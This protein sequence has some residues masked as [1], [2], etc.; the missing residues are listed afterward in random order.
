MTVRRLSGGRFSFLTLEAESS[1]CCVESRDDV[2]GCGRPAM[3]GVGR[4]ERAIVKNENNKWP[5]PNERYRRVGVKV[6]AR[7]HF[8]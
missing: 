4:V 3:D 8:Q 7:L 5:A 6:D 1:I 2:E